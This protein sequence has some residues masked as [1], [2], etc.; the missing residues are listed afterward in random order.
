MISLLFGSST[1]LST[2]GTELALAV[3]YI[4]NR[5]DYVL[6]SVALSRRPVVYR[7]LRAVALVLAALLIGVWVSSNSDNGYF[8]TLLEVV[9]A[10]ASGQMPIWFY[11]TY[12]IVVVVAL[13]GHWITGLCA[14][15][16]FRRMPTAGL[17]HEVEF[18]ETE[19]VIKAPNMGS[20]VHWSA[21]KRV[22]EDRTFFL[23]SLK[24]RQ[25]ILLPRRA[26]PDQ[27]SY[28][29]AL[30]FAHSHATAE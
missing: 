21:I 28:N 18:E 1:V 5:S 10:S 8:P 25:A 20:T 26:F 12:A 15:F 24:N 22:I 16:L 7:L 27:A 2:R 14:Y 6:M 23:I 3:S 4:F 11:G 13:F 29:S 17:R 30:A 19:V 9:K